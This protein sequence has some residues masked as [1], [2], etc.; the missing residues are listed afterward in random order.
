MVDMKKGGIGGGKRAIPLE[1]I[2]GNLPLEIS[3]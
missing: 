2:V 3:C 1:L